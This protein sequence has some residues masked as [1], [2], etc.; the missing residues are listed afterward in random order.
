MV[1]VAAAEAW[2]ALNCEFVA[3][4]G[5]TPLR[6]SANCI[7]SANTGAAAV[8]PYCVAGSSSTTIEARRGL[9]AGAY[10]MNE[11]IVPLE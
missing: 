10:P 11:A 7:T 2:A 8:P 9:F 5:A 3:S 1:P 4:S 6:V